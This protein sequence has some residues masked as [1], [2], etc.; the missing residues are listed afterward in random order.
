MFKQLSLSFCIAVVMGVLSQNVK[1]QESRPNKM[2]DDYTYE[3]NIIEERKVVPQPHLR[4]A[5]V[6]YRQRIHRVIDSRE[7]MN[8][9]MRWPKNPLHKVIYHAVSSGQITAYPYDSLKSPFSPE[10]AAKLGSREATYEVYDERLGRTRDSTVTEP[11]N[12]QDIVRYKLIEDWIFDKQRGLFFPRII[13]VAPL[14]KLEKEGQDL[15]Y[16]E[17]FYVKYDD[18]DD[19][20]VNEEVFNR[21]NDAMRLS[22]YDLFEQRLFSSFITKES[23]AFDLPI[24][25]FEEY[26]NDRIAALYKA[27]DIQ[28]EIFNFEHD[29]WEW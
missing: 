6:M 14:Y 10:E 1:A 9:I 25:A 27:Q 13:A 24:D 5:D 7:K 16:V 11:F 15:G 8:F 19:V 12:P 4:E 29:L 3:Q 20:L 17:L 28:E 26:Q 21:H 2:K 18:L 22:Y 23:N